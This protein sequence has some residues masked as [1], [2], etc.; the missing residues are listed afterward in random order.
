MWKLF[1]DNSYTV[2][3]LLLNQ[4][5]LSLFSLMLVSVYATFDFR[6]VQAIV[7]VFGAGLYLY[8]QYTVMWS[9]GAK[10]RVRVS[11]DHAKY[12]P[13]KGVYLA[14]F[15]NSI[16]LL[17]AVLATLSD[18]FG[19]A[20]PFFGNL[21]FAKV[22]LNLVQTMYLPLVTLF[23]PASRIPFYLYLLSPV[24]AIAVCGIA[25]ENGYRNR[26]PLYSTAKKKK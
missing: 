19:A 15:A 24:P 7:G 11:V 8:L 9:D 5:A 16:N 12:I 1:R 20:V 17:L 2:V 14:L 21:Q 13:G 18:F 3:R 26:L 23:V 22:V 10:D 25:F 6:S 4:I